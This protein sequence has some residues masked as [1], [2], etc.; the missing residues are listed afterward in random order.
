M[1][2]SVLS[3]CLQTLH[4]IFYTHMNTSHNFFVSGVETDILNQTTKDL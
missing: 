3:M 1:N 4:D 2:F